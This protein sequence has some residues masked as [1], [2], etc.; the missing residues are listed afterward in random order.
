MATPVKMAAKGLITNLMNDPAAWPFLKPVDPVQLNLP[1]Y[2]E[3]A[4]SISFFLSCKSPED[5]F[6]N[7]T[8]PL[9]V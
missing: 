7:P 9:S 4:T 3:S 2:F 6:S 1:D 5:S 8:Q